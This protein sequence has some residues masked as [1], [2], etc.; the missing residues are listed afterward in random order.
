MTT[1]GPLLDG[2]HHLKLPVSVVT[3]LVSDLLTDSSVEVRATKR[4]AGIP[5]RELLETVMYG[6][7]QL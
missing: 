2:V 1:D 6:L 7:Q 4:T 3:I 5:D